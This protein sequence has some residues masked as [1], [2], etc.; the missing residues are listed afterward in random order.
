MSLPARYA[1]SY[2]E[3]ETNMFALFALPTIH[4]AACLALAVRFAFSRKMED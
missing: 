3:I 4:L 1:M 2:A